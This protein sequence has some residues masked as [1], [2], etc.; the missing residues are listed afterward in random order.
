MILF[1]LSPC[2][3]VVL[4]FI[5]PVELTVFGEDEPIDYEMAYNHF[6]SP[7]IQLR[8]LIVTWVHYVAHWVAWIFLGS[9]WAM[10]RGD[11]YDSHLNITVNFNRLMSDTE[12]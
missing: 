2:L 11:Q 4:V 8:S 5:L 9:T 7:V 6:A 10:V 1:K 12:I 3:L